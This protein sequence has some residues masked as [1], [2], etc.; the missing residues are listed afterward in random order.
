MVLHSR[1]YS[2]LMRAITIKAPLCKAA[3]T[4]IIAGTCHLGVLSGTSS[5]DFAHL[6]RLIL[7]HLSNEVLVRQV[8]NGSLSPSHLIQC[9]TGCAVKSGQASP[10]MG[11]L[12]I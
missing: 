7:T 6:R 10:H 5:H 2:L 8:P 1:S 3:I 4:A 12:V 11:I 9:R